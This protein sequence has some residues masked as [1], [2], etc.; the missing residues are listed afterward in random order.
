MLRQNIVSANDPFTTGWNSVLASQQYSMPMAQLGHERRPLQPTAACQ[1]PLCPISDRVGVAA[2]YVATGQEPTWRQIERGQFAGVRGT[3]ALHCTG[4]TRRTPHHSRCLCSVSLELSPL[5]ESGLS[6]IK[7]LPSRL[8]TWPPLE[9]RSQLSIRTDIL[10]SR[11]TT[12]RS[13]LSSSMVTATALFADRRTL[14]P[15]TSATRLLSMK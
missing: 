3:N 14:S 7:R 9:V 5:L 2:Q 12:I 4:T 11:S 8:R 13:Y 15:S 6:C 1:L 10:P